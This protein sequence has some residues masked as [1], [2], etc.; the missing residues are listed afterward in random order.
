[1]YNDLQKDFNLGPR[2]LS[3]VPLVRGLVQY[4]LAP[5]FG[6]L[7]DCYSRRRLFTIGVLWW[8]VST[9]FI[10]AAST[11]A[12]LIVASALNAI[13]L[14]TV[15]PV[16][17]SLLTDYFPVEN[18]G[19]AFGW[20]GFS[21]VSGAIA[22]V[23]LPT[24]LEGVDFNTTLH[25]WRICTYILGA[26]V[27]V[28]SLMIVF[29]VK[30]PPR[31]EAVGVNLSHLK[32]IFANKTYLLVMMA[33]V[34]S[35]LSWDVF[36]FLVLWLQCMGMS[37]VQSG[38]AFS[39]CALGAAIGG[40]FGGY[41]GDWASSWDRDKGRIIVGQIS[42]FLGIPFA[43][44]FFGE[45]PRSPD[46]LWLFCVIGFCFGFSI[47]W[48]SS[49]C[50]LPILSEVVPHAASGTAYSIDRLIEGSAAAVG[51]LGLGILAKSYG[52]LGGDHCSPNM[53]AEQLAPMSAGLAN[54]L[55]LV[56]VVPWS[57]CFFV[58]FLLYWTYRRDRKGAF[59]NGHRD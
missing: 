40:L 13:G 11:F 20:L 59:I 36:S 50:N 41:A 16:S 22:G 19:K 28:L 1:V 14:A 52:Y 57:V 37:T 23:M 5:L 10:A 24:A 21:S 38:I 26:V 51:S 46:W 32:A 48:P 15:V 29:V 47:S 2:H 53:S 58:Y 30:N 8:G 17:Y 55:L 45:I 31:K 44:I 34:C 3:A 35:S 42:I 27:M 12:E 49:A 43:V 9:L 7:S 6:Y 25:N 33:G 4:S 56:M 39:S 18:R 54:A